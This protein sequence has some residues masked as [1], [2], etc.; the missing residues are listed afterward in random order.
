MDLRERFEEMTAGS[1]CPNWLALQA[2]SQAIIA[3]DILDRTQAN[4]FVLQHDIVTSAELANVAMSLF[5]ADLDRNSPN[6]YHIIARELLSKY[7]IER[8]V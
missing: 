6:H 3:K 2:I 8:K 5:S 1:Q 7:T 4:E